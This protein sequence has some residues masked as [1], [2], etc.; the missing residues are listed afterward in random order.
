[1]GVT[2]AGRP[3]Q[4]IELRLDRERPGAT[5]AGHVL[6]L[7]PEE[8]SGLLVRAF[9]QN[10][11]A[12]PVPADREGA[13]RFERL[14]P[15]TW[16]I[17]AMD[18][19]QREALGTVEIPPGIP[20]VEFDLKFP[21]GFSLTGRVLVDGA[22]LSQAIVRAQGKEG[23]DPNGRT[24]Y[25]GTF[26]L[27]D[28]AAGLTTL[29]VTGLPGLGGVRTLMLTESQDIKIEIATGRL[30]GTVVS[31]T[32]EPVEDA[33]VRMEA[34]RPEVDHSFAQS[35]ARTGADGAFEVPRLAAGSYKIKVSKEGF[36]P[37]E[38]TAEVPPGGSAP[39]VEILL[40]PRQETP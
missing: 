7:P 18:S 8:L 24:A 32:S 21:T 12:N 39:P 30:V 6:G 31:A 3:V 34:W 14:A 1:V 25:D 27:R 22:P 35:T 28:L 16:R 15:G 2:V 33:L 10:E 11:M 13:Y 17:E 26:E 20:A 4:G 19:R 38:T 36:A 37:A 40:K 23:F 9:G 5:L 29:V